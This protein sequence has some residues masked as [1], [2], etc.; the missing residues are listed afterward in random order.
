MTQ[1]MS[2]IPHIAA[3]TWTTC[4]HENCRVSLQGCSPASVARMSAAISGFLASSVPAHRG[5][6]AGYLQR[7]SRQVN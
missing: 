7:K 4:C 5:A 2:A 3:F 1:A 6:H